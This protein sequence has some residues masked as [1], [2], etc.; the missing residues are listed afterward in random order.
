MQHAFKT[1]IRDYESWSRELKNVTSSCKI[2]WK[3]KIYERPRSWELKDFRRNSG[4]NYIG[5]KAAGAHFSI[6]L[7]FKSHLHLQLIQEISCD[8]KI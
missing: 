2:L 1:E 5:M 7:T 6:V 4:K 8:A 3:A